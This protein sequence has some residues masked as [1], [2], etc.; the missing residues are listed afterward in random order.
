MLEPREDLFLYSNVTIDY[1]YQMI[2][3]D[4]V[5]EIIRWSF[6]TDFTNDDSDSD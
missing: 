6:D 5:L 1:F 4:I 3:L 2:L